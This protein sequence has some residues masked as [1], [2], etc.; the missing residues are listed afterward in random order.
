M[1][2]RDEYEKEKMT[3]RSGETVE[4]D[5]GAGDTVDGGRGRLIV[6]VFTASG[7]VPLEGAVVVVRNTPSGGG[8]IASLITDRSGLAPALTL[9]APPRAE[10][11]RP[12]GTLPYS[13]YGID[14][15][16]D[17]YYTP[18]FESVP[19]YD[20]ITSVQNVG[21]IPLPEN[22]RADGSREDDRIIYPESQQ[23][24]L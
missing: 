21:M 23:P 10:A 22:G 13:I 24:P 2:D 18:I 19:I 7:A 3:A 1:A 20:G 11:Q 17:G 16:L 8:I 14:V 4:D 6:R 5:K 15:F 9:P 12:G